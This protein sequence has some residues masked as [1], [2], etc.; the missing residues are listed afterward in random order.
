MFSEIISKKLTR[1]QRAGKTEGKQGSQVGGSHAPPGFAPVPNSRHGGYRKRH[2]ASW[3]YWYPDSG[4]SSHGEDDHSATTGKPA[5]AEAPA[6][7]TP[8]GDDPD[9]TKEQHETKMSADEM[10]AAMMAEVDET[11]PKTVAMAHATLAEFNMTIVGEDT[12]SA[13]AVAMLYAANIDKD[14]DFCK[15]APPACTGNLGVPRHDMPQIVGDSLADLIK[16]SGDRWKYDEIVKAG[17]DVSDHSANMQDLFLA[18]LEAT[19]IKVDRTGIEVK[20]SELKATQSQI[21][22]NKAAKFAKWILE[23]RFP[24]AP[25]GSCTLA[26]SPIVVTEDGYILDGHHRYAAVRLTGASKTMPTI[27]VGMSI[28]DLLTKSLDFPGVFRADINDK[29]ISNEADAKAAGAQWPRPDFAAYASAANKK[30]ADYKKSL[31]PRELLYA[32]AKAAETPDDTT[33]EAPVSDSPKEFPKLP[34]ERELQRMLD[35][36]DARI[37]KEKA[38]TPDDKAAEPDAKAMDK[39]LSP[40]R[41]RLAMRKG[42]KPDCGCDD[43]KKG[44]KKCDKCADKAKAKAPYSP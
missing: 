17:G 35:E 42:G 5:E 29:P 39:A 28:A 21:Q 31:S 14:I 6:K 33:P 36:D 30:V 20:V 11:D 9:A 27:Q 1:K 43:K 25:A 19:G 37:E 18:S 32:F 10:I 7:P 26:K 13:N 3:V 23:D 22:A 44:G 34:S 41:A 40:L 16:D 2:G 8:A 38:A 24:G 15:V 12:A 4:V